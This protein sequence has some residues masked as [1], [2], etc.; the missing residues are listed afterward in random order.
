MN[1]FKLCLLHVLKLQR[2]LSC[3]SVQK[4]WI[5]FIFII[6]YFHIYS[7]TFRS[8]FVHMLQLASSYKPSMNFGLL[9]LPVNNT[10]MVEQ[11][12]TCEKNRRCTKSLL[13]T[14]GLPFNTPEANEELVLQQNSKDEEDNTFNCHR[15]QVLPNK[16]PLQRVQSLFCA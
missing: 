7:T 13:P 14:K 8:H 16:V 3:V 12:F 10:F 2:Y 15:K 9:W 6:Y 4:T 5:I 11:K 1:K